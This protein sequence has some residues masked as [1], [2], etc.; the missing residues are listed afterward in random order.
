MAT[1]DELIDI[2]ISYVQPAMIYIYI[3]YIY[4]MY[5][6]FELVKYR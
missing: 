2:R 3:Y 6:Y 4:N 1:K 5:M